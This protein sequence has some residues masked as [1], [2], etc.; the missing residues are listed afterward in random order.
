M[1]LIATSEQS[2]F[3]LY[4]LAYAK[5]GETLESMGKERFG[6]EGIVE[7][8]RVAPSLDPRAVEA[9]RSPLALRACRRTTTAPRMTQTLPAT[10]RATLTPAAVRLLTLRRRKA[11]LRRSSASATDRHD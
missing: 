3:T 7:L 2:D 1:S 4:F 6:R 9:D 10:P 11:V 8:V 5:E